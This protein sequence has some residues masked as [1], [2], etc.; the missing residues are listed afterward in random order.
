M[1]LNTYRV[2]IKKYIYSSTTIA[3]SL[4]KGLKLNKNNKDIKKKGG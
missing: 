3:F 4:K 1:H 2:Y